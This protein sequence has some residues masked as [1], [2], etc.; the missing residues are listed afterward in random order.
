MQDLDRRIQSSIKTIPPENRLLLTYHDSFPMFGLQYGVKI[1]GAVQPSNFT[2]PSAREVARLIKQIQENK[3]P[4]IFGSEVFP[5][6]IM[7]QIAKE[8]GAEFIDELRD[9]D[10]PGNPGDPM[11]SYLGLILS[12]MQIMIPALGGNTEALDGFDTSLVFKEPSTAIY[13]Q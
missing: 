7:A 9:D 10:L 3:V 6:P 1:L 5:S 2:E 11:H 12:D 4:A 13:P 8:G